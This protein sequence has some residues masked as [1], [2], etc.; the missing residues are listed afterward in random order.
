MEYTYLGDRNT[1]VK[2]RKQSCSA[3]R[4][5]GKCVRGKNGSMLVEFADG[6]QRVVI[7]RLLRKKK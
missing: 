7:G 5:N 4:R 6:S 2:L 3:V 1:D